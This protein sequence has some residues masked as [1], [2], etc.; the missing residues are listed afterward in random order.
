MTPTGAALVASILGPMAWLIVRG[1]RLK[2]PAPPHHTNST[3]SDPTT[4]VPS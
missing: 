3:E 4:E 1:D 2:G